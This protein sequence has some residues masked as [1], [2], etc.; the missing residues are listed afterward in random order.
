M[1]YSDFTMPLVRQWLG[2][3]IDQEGDLFRD[4]PEV[5]LPPDAER[6]LSR[7]LPLAVSSTVKGRSEFLVAPILIDLTFLYQ[8][9]LSYHSGVSLPVAPEAGLGG[10]CDFVLSCDPCQLHLGVPIRLIVEASDEATVSGVPRCLA[11]MVAAR[12]YDQGAGR[13]TLPVYGAVTT[14]LQWR[15]LRLDGDDAVVDAVE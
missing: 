15:F 8:D 1:A 11:E 4:T 3:T 7:Y 10:R 2:L 9:Q 5:D 13:V 14:G 12:S 6:R